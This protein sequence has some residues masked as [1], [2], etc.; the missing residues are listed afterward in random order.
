M[1]I[2]LVT[3]GGG[4]I[5]RH[6][7][8]QLLQRNHQVRVLDIARMDGN[9][10][11]DVEIY[12]G[13]ILDETLLAKAMKGTDYLFHLAANPHLWAPDKSNFHRVNFEGTKKVLENVVKNDVSKI[14]YTSSE[15]LLKSYRWNHKEAVDETFCMP[16]LEELPGPYSRS[17]MLA[18]QEVRKAT[19]AGMPVIIVYP[20]TPVGP[21]DVNFTP[22][23]RM[24]MDFLNG[25]NPAYLDCTLNYIA[26]EDVALGHI[27]AAEK[28]K[29]GERYILG[30]QNLWLS[31]V[32]QILEQTF[33][34]PMPKRR[35]SYQIALLSAHV[36]EFIA[37][38]ITRRSPLASVEG[39]RLAGT[40]L[41]FDGNK[42]RKELGLPEN[43]I[44]HAFESAI[45]WLQH[46]GYVK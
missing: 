38:H 36:S 23:T 12:Q 41:A 19:E 20:T 17:K 18:E 37:D 27:L 4:F 6:L 9:F 33:G 15:T 31:E 45:H 39:V 43:N 25:K 16:A 8:H 7:V 1:A 32:L 42:A 28:G 40:H 14:V 24:I 13:S 44:N 34:K 5:G 29:P 22:P 10:P 30:N 35:I 11:P 3:G 46:H 21:G 2:S 26:V